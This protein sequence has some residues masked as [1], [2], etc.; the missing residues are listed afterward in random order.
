MD[1][2]GVRPR[3]EWIFQQYSGARAGSN[4]AWSNGGLDPWSAGGVLPGSPRDTAATPAFLMPEG[5]HHLDLFFSNAADPASVT[6]V[7]KAQVALMEKWAAEWRA[8]G[9]RDL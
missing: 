1:K 9:A 6:A 4:I 5:A 8:A 2:F 7:R 3:W